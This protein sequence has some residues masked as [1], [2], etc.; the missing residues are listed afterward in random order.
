[1][2][3][4]FAIRR[5]AVPLKNFSRPCRDYSDQSSQPRTKRPGLN[6]DVPVG[7][8]LG[9]KQPGNGPMIFP[10][11]RPGLIQNQSSALKRACVRPWA[12]SVFHVS[13]GRR[14]RLRST[15]FRA[16]G[17]PHGRPHSGAGGIMMGIPTP[18]F[19]A[20]LTFSGRPSGPRRTKFG[21]AVLIPSK[22][23]CFTNKN[24]P[25]A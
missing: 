8:G 13:T 1:M 25:R 3:I 16:Y 10:S 14:G 20:G 23:C 11:L 2:W 5:G 22:A 9:S 6:S 17:S 21:N 15:W 18:P 12:E 7:T 19:R 24:V 4:F